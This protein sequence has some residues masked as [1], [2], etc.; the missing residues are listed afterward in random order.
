MHSEYWKWKAVRP[1][2]RGKVWRRGV[3]HNGRLVKL[4]LQIVTPARHAHE[5]STWD[6]YIDGERVNSSPITDSREARK[7]IW[8]IFNGQWAKDP[9]NA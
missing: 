5:H 9:A 7:V 1:E 6:C 8:R 2:G 4:E 3:R